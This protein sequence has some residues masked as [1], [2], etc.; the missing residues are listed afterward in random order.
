MKY[1][2]GM[3]LS[4]AMSAT[5]AVDIVAPTTDFVHYTYAMAAADSVSRNDSCLPLYPSLKISF[6]RCA[7]AGK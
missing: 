5:D 2:A 4:N 1:A 6:F 3:P 7:Y